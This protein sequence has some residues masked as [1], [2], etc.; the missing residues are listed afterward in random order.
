MVKVTRVEP[1]R[2][3]R[4]RVEFSDGVRGEVDLTD[5]LFGS[6]FEPLKDVELFRKV[7][8]E[9]EPGNRWLRPSC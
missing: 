2:R 9:S 8:I 4:L 5:R 6:V 7:A 1:I 3:Y